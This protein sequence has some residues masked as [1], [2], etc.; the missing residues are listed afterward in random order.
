MQI[1]ETL[2]KSGNID[3]IVVDSVAALTP[4]REIEGEIGDQHMGLQARLMS[5]ACRKLSGIMAKSNTMVIFLNQTRM[6]IGM[7]FGCLNYKS[8]INLADGGTECI[9]KIV[10]QKKKM[11]ILSY[12]WNK[13]QIISRSINGWFNNGRTDKFLQITAY[14]PYGNGKAQ[15]SCTPNHPILT[16]TGWREADQLKKGDLVMVAAP[17]K[18]SHFQYEVIRGSIMGDGNLS[19]TIHKK[20]LGIRFRMGHCLK[21]E[22][23]LK[24]KMNLLKNI[25][26]SLFNSL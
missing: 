15:F 19:N 5:Q 11:D 13:R 12:D 10:N 16:P 7:V 9:G 22:E 14:K 23:Y 24:W 21:Q 20:S 25:S 6:K 26:G 3:V 4:Q 2:V 17:F 18:L 1:V 8:K